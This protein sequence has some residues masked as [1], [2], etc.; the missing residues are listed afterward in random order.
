MGNRHY[1]PSLRRLN[2]V[3]WLTVIMIGFGYAST[4]SSGPEAQEWG[5]HLGH[6]PSWFGIQVL[7][8]LSGW[9]G[10]RTLQSGGAVKSYLISRAARTYPWVLLY[11]SAVLLIAYPWLTFMGGNEL[12][13]VGQSPLYFLKTITLLDPGGP[14]PGVLGQAAYEGLLQ[15]AIWTL[16]WG[17]AIHIGFA[18]L[19]WLIGT[20]RTLLTALS[21]LTVLS[22][23]ALFGLA[24][25]GGL[26]IPETVLLATRLG[27]PF[28]LGACLMAWS[29]TFKP[30]PVVS[31]IAALIA[32]IVATVHYVALPWTP[33]IEL[34]GTVGWAFVAIALIAPWSSEK[35][36]HPLNDWP[37]LTLPTYLGLW[38][39]SQIWLHLL[40][41]IA[42]SALILLTLSSATLLALVLRSIAR[43]LIRHRRVQAT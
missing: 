29:D 37:N 34:L 41:S 32:F 9:L 18:V 3:R 8:F 20:H 4:M 2:A 17:L 15:G 19:F 43:H 22:Y 7:F 35:D 6:D 5:A 24:A 23:A 28:L 14:L 1:I 38:P 13:P 39:L 16:R 11:T 33:A 30:G 21:G 40:P 12:L 42:I 26:E 27:Y 10:W 36:G 25:K 31:L